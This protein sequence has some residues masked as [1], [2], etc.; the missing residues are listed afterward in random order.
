MDGGRCPG[1]ALRDL[2]VQRSPSPCNGLD[3]VVAWMRGVRVSPSDV[4][5]RLEF[6]SSSRSAGGACVEVA[7]SARDRSVTVRNSRLREQF[8]LTF[9]DQEWAAFLAGVKAGEFD[10]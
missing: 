4:P 1:C 9:T 7:R 10:F 8:A 6:R 3:F 2:L 5:E